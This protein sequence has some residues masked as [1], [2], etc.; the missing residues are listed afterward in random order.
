RDIKPSRLSGGQKQKVALARTLITRPKVLLLDEPF[1][2]LDHETK[3]EMRREIGDILKVHP[4]PT[5]LVTHDNMDAIALGS[6]VA[7]MEKGKIIF[8]EEIH[9]FKRRL[10]EWNGFYSAPT[11]LE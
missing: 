11:I 9:S 4:M 1:S 8:Y 10:E 5:V 7:F 2:A 6:R 3:D